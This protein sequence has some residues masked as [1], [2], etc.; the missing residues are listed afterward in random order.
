M[1]NFQK[2]LVIM[3]VVLGILALYAVSDKTAQS[4]D[5]YVKMIKTYLERGKKDQVDPEDISKSL[6]KK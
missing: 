4:D 3:A 5:A 2:F 6:N 1:S